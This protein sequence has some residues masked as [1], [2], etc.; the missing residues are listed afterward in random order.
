MAFVKEYIDIDNIILVIWTGR[1]VLLSKA[2]KNKSLI[3][4]LNP[5]T[6]QNQ[7]H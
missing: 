5:K 7:S 1:S 2:K 6:K 3:L 4:Q